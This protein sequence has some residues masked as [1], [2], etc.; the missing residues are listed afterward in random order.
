MAEYSAAA[1]EVGLR[2]GPVED[3]SRHTEHFWTTTAALMEAE[4][5]D[6]N[7]GPTETARRD[8]SMRAHALMRQGLADEGLHYALMSLSK[9]RSSRPPYSRIGITT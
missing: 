3:I 2:Q 8:A 1:V 4:A 5:R 6:K 9:D 7:S